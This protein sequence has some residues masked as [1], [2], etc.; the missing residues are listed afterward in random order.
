MGMFLGSGAQAVDTPYGGPPFSPLHPPVHP[1]GLSTRNTDFS[2]GLLGCT[3]RPAKGQRRE[4]L[5]VFLF[6]W[7]GRDLN[8]NNGCSW[9][10][11]LTN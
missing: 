11:G 3:G 6:P 7:L 8:K 9:H 1:L 4:G 10:V 2:Q 5:D